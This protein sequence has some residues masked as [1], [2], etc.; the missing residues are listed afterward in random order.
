[1]N[2]QQR[3]FIV[4]P[5]VEEKHSK[6]PLDFIEYPTER[7][8]KCPNIEKQLHNLAMISIRASQHSGL[9]LFGIDKKLRRFTFS[10]F[11][12]PVITAIVRLLIVSLMT[13]YYG[14][15]KDAIEQH[16]AEDIEQQATLGMTETILSGTII[17]SDVIGMIL[18]W[19]N[20]EQVEDFLN[21]FLQS[22]VLF[23]EELKNPDWVSGW[24]N[25]ASKRAR[26]LVNGINFSANI[27]ILI[28]MYQDVLK[29]ILVIVGKEQMS[30]GDLKVPIF[31][32]F[33]FT[34]LFRRLHC[35]I[36]LMSM[37]DTLQFG[38]LTVKEHVKELANEKIK[39]VGDVRISNAFGRIGSS[40]REG[41]NGNVDNDITV[42][43]YVR[44][45]KLN[46]ILEMY[47]GMESLLGEF[48]ELYTCHMLIGILSV[49][50]VML[51]ALFH[52]FVKMN[53]EM[54]RDALVFAIEAGLHIWVL[55]SLGTSATDMATEA[56]SCIIALRDVPLGTIDLELKRKIMLHFQQA[57]AVPLVV[58]P[59]HFFSLNRK[60]LTSAK[61]CA[62]V[63]KKIPFEKASKNYEGLKTAI[64]SA[65][66]TYL[67][68]LVQ[69]Q[70]DE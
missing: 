39:T 7:S 29:I 11:S 47:R 5:F 55:N 67:L 60:M 12:C 17:S 9:F 4:E 65:V 33:W 54:D 58:A 56:E 61:E 70:H 2:M 63:L 45:V 8:W 57:L 6:L 15:S 19:R 59:G 34:I 23:T 44:Q 38:F 10:W 26:W 64:A 31:T 62:S 41:K 16:F 22:V 20:R 53:G 13:I 43:D 49:L 37:I 27:S 21:R 35:R 48:N 52:F 28:T 14:T 24:F 25:Q 51:L 69:F 1:M 18:F 40:T 32:F 50:T 3:I 46:K 66:T 36:V 42:I 30:W 68:V